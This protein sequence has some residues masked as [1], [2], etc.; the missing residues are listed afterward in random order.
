M[1]FSVSNEVV[2][3]V[4]TRILVRSNQPPIE[5][6]GPYSKLGKTLP[7]Y[8]LFHQI[9]EGSYQATVLDPA[10]WTHDHPVFYRIKFS[11]TAIPA[12]VGI[13]KNEVCARS[14]FVDGRR[15]VIRAGSIREDSLIADFAGLR[16]AI[17]VKCDDIP[18]LET[19]TYQGIPVL[20]DASSE[21]EL[22]NLAYLT[23]WP[24][25]MAVIL[26]GSLT[27]DFVSTAGLST[28]PLRLARLGP[29][30]QLP[31]WAHGAVISFDS[32]I[33]MKIDRN[34]PVLAERRTADLVGAAVIRR[35]CERLQCDLAPQ[36]NLA[37]YIVR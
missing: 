7:V 8:T 25:V 15:Y 24:C 20:V 23:S 22:Q 10:I 30:D 14:V 4:S 16:L 26:P 31:S 37:G 6:A 1:E 2:T 34:Y 19:A 17:L 32:L 12:I 9:G 11:E 13:R 28:N 36:Y 35:S 33:S 29:R 3:P 5:I 18:R 27:N 21:N